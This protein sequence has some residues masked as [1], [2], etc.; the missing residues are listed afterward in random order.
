MQQRLVAMQALYTDQYPDVVRL[1]DL[2]AKMEKRIQ[3]KNAA[4]PPTSEPKVAA[5]SAPEPTP[6]L[7]LRSQIHS[8]DEAIRVYTAEQDRIRKQIKVYEGRLQLSPTVEQQYKE[9]TR[10]HD[11]A[12][13]IYNSLLQ[14]RDES[15]MATDLERAQQGEQFQI[16]DPADLPQKPDFPNRLKFAGGGLGGGLALGIV[17]ALLL[18][19][20]DKSLRTEADVEL[21]LGTSPLAKIPLVDAPGNGKKHLA[22]LRKKG[23]HDKHVSLGV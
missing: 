19:M 5:N 6:I 21:F 22:G 2:I 18:E 1:K 20:L 13:K 3:T 23:T 12:L 15:A 10:D 8:D 16:M 4:P 14:K 7:Q 9:I 11:T 17:L